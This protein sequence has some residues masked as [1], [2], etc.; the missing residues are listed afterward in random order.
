M[1][2]PFLGHLAC[3][4]TSLRLNSRSRAT[5]QPAGTGSAQM[6]CSIA[7][8]RRGASSRKVSIIWASYQ[9]RLR[10]PVTL[11]GSGILIDTFKLTGTGEADGQSPLTKGR[12]PCDRATQHGII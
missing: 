12:E 10:K 4:A 2:S 7:P 11:P 1:F 9:A 3:V 6:R 5:D 8:Q